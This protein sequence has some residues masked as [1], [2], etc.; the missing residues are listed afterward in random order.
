MG[1]CNNICCILK[2]TPSSWNSFNIFGKSSLYILQTLKSW[3]K[4]PS[5]AKNLGQL[6]STTSGFTSKRNHTA[7][8]LFSFLYLYCILHY[9]SVGGQDCMYASIY[10]PENWSF[11]LLASWNPWHVGVL[12]LPVNNINEQSLQ[13]SS[14]SISLLVYTC[15]GFKSWTKSKKYT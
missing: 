12:W 13:F 5:I 11:G 4:V 6:L 9:L 2:P 3:W 7:I 1:Y 14:Y 15:I 8:S 10:L